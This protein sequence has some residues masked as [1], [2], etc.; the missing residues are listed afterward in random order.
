MLMLMLMPMLLAGDCFL[1]D[2]M[3]HVGN[4]ASR[5]C[6]VFSGPS[7]DDAPHMHDGNTMYRSQ[8]SGYGIAGS[9][10][11]LTFFHDD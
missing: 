3:A 7:K 1:A 8:W 11:F 2:W 6:V 4:Q 10:R 9:V 5:V